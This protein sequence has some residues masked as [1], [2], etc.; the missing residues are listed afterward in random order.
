MAGDEIVVTVPGNLTADPELRFTQSGTAVAN[1]TVASTPRNFDRQANEWR[2]G[3]TTFL[4]CTAWR[5]LAENIAE[6][7]EKGSPVIVQ[8]NLITKKF[9]T[10]E[11]EARSAHEI[12]ATNVG[13]NLR[14]G[15][16]KF[17]KNQ[18]KG[19]GGNGGYQQGGGNRQGNTQ[20]QGSGGAPQGGGQPTANDD[21]WGSGGTAND[22]PWG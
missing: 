5:E 13:P 3:E 7:F 2:D 12:D 10:R 8:G 21:P 11:G 4:K 16:S 14:Y 17:T 6:S 18:R 20:P 1:F 9:T 15:S 22:D 19:G